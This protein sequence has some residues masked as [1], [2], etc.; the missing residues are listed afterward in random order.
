MRRSLLLL[1]A[2]A[3]LL[4]AGPTLAQPAEPGPE[5]LRALAELLRDPGIRAWLQTQAEAAPL[6]DGRAA[7]SGPDSPQEV[8]ANRLDAMRAFL[9]ELV[10]AVPTLP[11]ELGRAWTVLSSEL[12]AQGLLG[13][14]ALLA[15]FA[16]LGFGLEW[17]FWWATTGFRERMIA[18]DLDTARN[19]GL[20]IVLMDYGYTEI[21]ASELGADRL[22]SNFRDVP[23]AIDDLLGETV[24]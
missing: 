5:Q 13:V 20:P 3:G 11:S 7:T 6:E 9:H 15:V 22:L 10:A 1:I 16:G 12:E 14:V 24:P 18:T 4:A 19:A 17:L 2:L 21:P 8:M 23:A